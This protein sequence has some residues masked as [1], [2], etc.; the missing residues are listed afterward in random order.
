MWHTASDHP[1]ALLRAENAIRNPWILKTIQE[2]KQKTCQVLDIG[3][4]A[5]LL[6][7]QLAQA[8]HSV[9]GIDLSL[10]SLEVAQ[11]QNTGAVFLE[12]DATRLPFPDECFDIVCAMD[13]L[14]HVERPELVVQEASRVL[15]PEG[16]FF[17][18]TFNRNWLSYLIIIKGVEWFVKNA[19]K[20]MHIYSL[21][22]KP[23]EL[24]GMMSEKGLM[25][26]N[27][28]GLVP[29]PA[30]KA[31]W[32][33]LAKRVIDKEFRFKFSKNLQTGYVGWAS[34]KPYDF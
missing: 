12:A 29:D 26:Q 14:E 27:I 33:M 17:F 7:N 9:T 19:P 25:L 34:K 23:K 11:A 32:K 31:F 21:F 18:H 24:K 2:R 20:N 8:A 4:G 5:G 30:S 13:L 10:G 28:Q 6:S 1:I 16:I 15:K 22:I 3:C